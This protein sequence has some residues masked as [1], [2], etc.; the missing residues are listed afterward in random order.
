MDVWEEHFRLDENGQ[1]VGLTAIG[2]T[3]AYVLGMNSEIRMHI[4]REILQLEVKD[5]D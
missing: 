4:R 3:T 1:I 5:D 2:H